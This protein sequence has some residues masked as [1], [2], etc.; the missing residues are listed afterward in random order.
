MAARKT[1]GR[2]GRSRAAAAAVADVPPAAG[3]S[4]Q[5]R[6]D[7]ANWDQCYNFRNIFLYIGE[8]YCPFLLK[9]NWI[10]VLVF[11]KEKRHFSG[12]THICTANSQ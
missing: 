1:V 2:S 4:S 9:T 3:L 11:F 6:P 7:L 5:R 8:K 10:I 12:K